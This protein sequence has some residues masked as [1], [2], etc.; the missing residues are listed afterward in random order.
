MKYAKEYKLRSEQPSFKSSSNNSTLTVSI[1]L[2]LIQEFS[3][4]ASRIPTLVNL[5]VD[6]QASLPAGYF[7]YRVD[8]VEL[9]EQGRKMVKYNNANVQ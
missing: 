3:L 9:S 1:A 2:L 5:K 7:Y 8:G 6:P 4:T